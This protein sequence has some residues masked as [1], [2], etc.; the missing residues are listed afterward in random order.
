MLPY[1]T[2]VGVFRAFRHPLW[3]IWTKDPSPRNVD[4]SKMDSASRLGTLAPKTVIS[5][6]RLELS[7]PKIKPTR[8]SEP[9]AKGL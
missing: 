1:G 3:T 7:C 6:S 8:A 5:L 2:P 9:L 4:W